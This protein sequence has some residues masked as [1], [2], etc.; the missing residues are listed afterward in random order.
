MNRSNDVELERVRLTGAQETTLATLYGKAMESRRPD[1]ILS[2]RE[3]DKALRRIDYDF[4]RLRIRRSDQLSL[5]VRA[6]AYDGWA[7]QFL[8]RHP[9]CTVLHLGCGLGTRVYR[10]DPPPTVR[11]YDIDLPDVIDLRPPA[12]G[13]ARPAPRLRPHRR[14]STTS[15]D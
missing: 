7:R 3:A 11:W 9:S 2:D 4:G 12:G 10:V 15:R 5:A 6:K 1:S 14:S 8:D 13:V